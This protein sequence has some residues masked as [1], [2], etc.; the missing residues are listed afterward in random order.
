M[1]LRIQLKL[2]NRYR[3]RI[4][5]TKRPDCTHLE[6]NWSLHKSNH[7][8][9]EL[10]PADWILSKLAWRCHRC[11]FKWG[12]NIYSFCSSLAYVNPFHLPLVRGECH[13]VL[14]SSHSLSACSVTH[15][16]CVSLSIR[17]RE[18]QI[19]LNFSGRWLDNKLC[20]K[21]I[22]FGKTWRLCGVINCSEV[23]NVVYKSTQRWWT[24]SST[25]I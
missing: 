6:T 18:F 10:M 15:A 17:Q 1:E 9:R 7:S 21:C 20:Q 19:S 22:Q 12:L 14:P 13:L 4:I 23:G 16:R 2:K 24:Q 3:Y 25:Q 11:H 5:I 8:F